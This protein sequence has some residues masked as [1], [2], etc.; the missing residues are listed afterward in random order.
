MGA[1]G[2]GVT[3]YE[4]GDPTFS[5]IFTDL[6]NGSLNGSI[7]HDSSSNTGDV[8]MALQLLYGNLGAG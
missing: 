4:E 3:S 2:A 1:P 7:A 8:S 6:Q 5:P